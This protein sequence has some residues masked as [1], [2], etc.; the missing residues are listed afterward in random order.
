[1]EKIKVSLLGGKSNVKEILESDKSTSKIF[2]EIEIVVKDSLNIDAN[3]DIMIVDLDK[4]NI[5]IEELSYLA[6]NK[7]IILCVDKESDILEQIV[8]TNI[9][10]ILLRPLIPEMVYFAL[11]NNLEFLKIKKHSE[12]ILQLDEID[13]L[14]GV[15]NRRGLS[16]QY[17][18]LNKK[19]KLHFMF[20]DIDDFKDVND[21]YGHSV[22]DK[23]LI[24]VTK[25]IRKNAPN[26][27]LFR[28]GGD[29]FVLMFKGE[30]TEDDVHEI[31]IK[32]LNVT[33]SL[34][35]GKEILTTIS[36]SI[37]II[38]NQTSNEKL[39]DI[40][41]KCDSAMYQA[42]KKGKN[43]YVM[44]N[45]IEKNLLYKKS[46]AKEKK[47]AL[48]NG[49]FILYLQP[50]MNMITRRIFGAE[51]LVRW[52]HPTE[53]IRMPDTF[54]PYFEE[55]GFI[56][57][58]DM[59]VFE[60]VCKLKNSWKDSTI[61]K[62]FIS[63]NMSR[64]HLHHK[65]FVEDLLN[66]TNKYQ[67]SPTELEIEFTESVFVKDSEEMMNTVIEL[68]KHGFTV[69]VDDFGAGYS[70]LNILK[71][72]PIDIIK[73]DREFLEK[74]EEDSKSRR[75]IR[76]IISMAKDLRLDTVA[77]GVETQEQ[78][79]FLTGCGCEL[80]QGF[81]YSK[82]L[83][84]DEYVEFANEHLIETVKLVNYRFD[85]NF[86]DETKEYL[87]VFDGDNYSFVEGVAK[88]TKALA[89]P[90]GS[91]TENALII[92][93]EALSSASSTISFWM[94]PYELRTWTSVFYVGFESGF[95]SV[96]P[97]AWEGVTIVRVKD[98]RERGGWYDAGTVPTLV[99]KW[100]HIT[101]TY[102]SK[103]ETLRLYIDAKLTGTK[104]YVP[105]MS[106]I[107]QMMLGGDVYKES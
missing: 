45:T 17:Q 80:A 31:A 97:L 40:L 25:L 23:L 59:Y 85:D 92:P 8:K 66:I 1:M 4:D 74:F 32:L 5:N 27:T 24:T 69:S 79:T 86:E 11:K 34:E 56:I 35:I 14:T 19:E 38:L 22:G 65:N 87:A 7:R 103:S 16:K 63:V 44:F 52:K 37:G 70:T 73:I 55:N 62:V 68:K 26:A 15:F 10:N 30:I 96:V 60:E 50:K 104:Y 6:T 2:D 51:A 106:T 21:L 76:S 54:I 95:L 84:V 88:G 107:R 83:P 75:I 90:G 29:E 9:T 99:D 78:I 33:S 49:E 39:D 13:Y 93:L 71:D 20:I 3:I 28:V 42:K 57:N 47:K 41:Y 58:L 91:R 89:F 81:F 102:D 105:P 94:R 64:L 72:T 36:L 53:G 43:Q 77:E 100:S 82:P 101:V 98:E 46:L 67:V 18:S 48:D 12:V 61:N